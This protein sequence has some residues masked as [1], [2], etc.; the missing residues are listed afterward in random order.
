MSSST[1]ISR[2]YDLYEFPYDLRK[3]KLKN[4]EDYGKICGKI[5]AVLKGNIGELQV[6]DT[7]NKLPGRFFARYPIKPYGD[8]KIDIQGFYKST[9]FLIQVKFTA[10][11][12]GY[13]K[14]SEEI[15]NFA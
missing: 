15:E 6:L 12:F 7:L 9:H 1:N 13:G 5:F 11:K 14:T 2:P 10:K 4:W 8:G 3:E